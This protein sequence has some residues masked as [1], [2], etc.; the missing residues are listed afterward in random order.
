MTK[1]LVIPDTQVKPNQP[2]DHLRW[3]RLYAVDK[4]PDVIIHI[5]DHFDMPSLSSW[6]IGKKSFEGRRYTDDIESGIKGMEA[7][8]API[9]EEQ[10]RLIKNKH[11][12]WNPRLVFTL[13]NHEQRIERAIEADPKLDGLIGYHD[14]KLDEFGFEVYDFLEVAVIDGIAY[15]HYFTSGVMGRPVSSARNMLS[16]KMMSCVMGHVQD[17]DIAFAR[18]ADGKNILGLFAGIFY[19]HDEDYLTAQTNG[20]W[21]GIWML[22]EVD[23]GSC[24]EMPITLTYLR[25]R[26]GEAE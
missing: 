16:K 25:K 7:F 13:G 20:S 19:Q 10:Q 4:K 5:G 12:Q 23:D 3:A 17:K 21:R 14:F 26:Y 15:S 6:D 1:H 18:R 9:R 2:I 11:K 24:E 22:N 8:I